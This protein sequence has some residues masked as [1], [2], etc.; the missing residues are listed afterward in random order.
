MTDNGEVQPEAIDTLNSFYKAE[1]EY[2]AS[3][4]GDFTAIAS[5]LDPDCVIFQPSSLPYGGEWRGH[6]GFESWMKAF[7][8]QWTYMEVKN[9][10]LYALR[11]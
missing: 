10:Q 5:T 9:S 11:T 2:L 7:A 6:V 8:Q 4:S 1:A 3:G